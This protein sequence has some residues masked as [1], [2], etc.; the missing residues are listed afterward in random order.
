MKMIDDLIIAITLAAL[1]A[2]WF[3]WRAVLPTIGALWV[4]GVL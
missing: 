2:L 1:A 4:F 3:G